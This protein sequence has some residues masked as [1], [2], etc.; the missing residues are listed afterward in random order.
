MKS[1]LAWLTALCLLLNTAPLAAAQKA[2]LLK[3]ASGEV[4]IQRGETRF[5][6]RRERTF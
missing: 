6:P 4:I 3:T 5:A 1:V 2:G